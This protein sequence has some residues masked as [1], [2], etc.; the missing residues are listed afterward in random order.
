MYSFIKRFFDFF[1]SFFTIIF[2][3]PIFIFL[4][5]LSIYK[6][7]FPVLFTHER[8]GTNGNSFKIIKFRTMTVGPSLSA[9][10][11]ELRLTNYGRFLRKTSMDELPVLIN[12]LKGEMSLVGPRPMPVKYF[13]R[14][15]EQQ[16]KRFKVK[17]GIT[18]L[19]Q[20][21]GRNNLTWEEK[22]K[23]DVKYVSEKSI[24]LD[25]IILI[26]TFYIVFSGIGI[27]AKDSEITPEFM[28]T[29]NDHSQ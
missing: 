7:G 8:L 11:D 12:V 13:K 20:I 4:Y 16:L 9:K 2:L 5:L 22:F 26:K 28:G 18:G 14:F 15:N 10:N 21:N 27:E 6:Q 17:P 19:A 24:I 25:L 1:L 29:E 3:I 23:F